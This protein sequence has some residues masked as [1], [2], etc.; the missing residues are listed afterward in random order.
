VVL[1][2]AGVARVE[3][4]NGWREAVRAGAGADGRGLVRRSKE[5]DLANRN[6]QSLLTWKVAK[7][8]LL[9]ELEARVQKYEKWSHHDVD[10][11]LLDIEKKVALPPSPFTPPS[12]LLPP[13]SCAPP[14]PAP[15]PALCI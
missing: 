13:P 12:S 14:R 3:R 1:A 15:L 9:A 8:Q 5:L 11:L 7:T 4:S 6:K 2:F 10:K